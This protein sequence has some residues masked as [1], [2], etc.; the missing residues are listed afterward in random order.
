LDR[1]Q[2]GSTSCELVLCFTSWVNF[3]TLNSE[4]GHVSVV[5]AKA[6]CRLGVHGMRDDCLPN[7]A[8]SSKYFSRRLMMSSVVSISVSSM[9]GALLKKKS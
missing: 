8:G 2:A 4:K 9:L 5:F 1:S 3:L 7:A 6:E